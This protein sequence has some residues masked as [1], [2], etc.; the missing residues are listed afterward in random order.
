MRTTI[1]HKDAEVLIER[2][3]DGRRL[4]KVSPLRQ[5]LFV[6]FDR[7][8]TAYPFELI[9]LILNTKGPA[10]LCDEMMRDE[11]PAYVQR[12]LSHDL[13]AYFD[14]AYFAHKRVLDFGCG[15]G[16]ST[17][18]LARMFPT[19]EIVG[20]ELCPDLLSVARR[21]VDFYGFTNVRLRQSPTGTEL[22]ADIGQFDVVIMSAVYE[23]LLPDERRAIMPKIW[24]TIRGGGYLFINQT[25]NL[26]HPVEAHTTGLPL[27]N[28]MPKPLAMAAARRFSKRIDRDDTWEVLLR[29]GIRGATEREILRALRGDE[30]HRA[31][32]IEPDRRG[33]HDRIDLWYS[34]LSPDRMRAVKR[35]LKVLMKATW[36]W[37]GF[38]FMP[39]LT[40]VIQK[41]P[42][43]E[44]GAASK[45]RVIPRP[46]VS[47]VTNESQP[48]G[49]EM[50]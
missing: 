45:T 19:A 35:V 28:Y 3:P 41:R 27:L 18:I 47:R 17:V 15:S 49:K 39:S 30:R 36:R 11:D 21:R 23:H 50:T 31:I 24:N 34:A 25:P 46:S 14:A 37:F 44:G 38:T 22:P 10:Y 32:L 42:A 5:D 48:A 29:K 43:G 1:K 16:A 9:Q 2:L 8:L 13:L 7:W 12:K 26:M 33:L 20:A 4:V 40:L 6:P